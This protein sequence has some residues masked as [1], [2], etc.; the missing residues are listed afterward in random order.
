MR[1][2]WSRLRWI[3]SNHPYPQLDSRKGIKRAT[4]SSRSVFP[5]LLVFLHLNTQSFKSP[6]TMLSFNFVLF[7]LAL[8]PL[9]LGKLS[10]RV[11][12]WVCWDRAYLFLRPAILPLAHSL[13][14][15]LWFCLISCDKQEID[16]I[17]SPTPDQ[18]LGPGP[19][20]LKFKARPST[21]YI[22]LA[23]YSEDLTV[24]NA[25]NQRYS[26]LEAGRDDV[27][28]ANEVYIPCGIE[29]GKYILTVSRLVWGVKRREVGR[30]AGFSSKSLLHSDSLIYHVIRLRTT[31][32][33]RQVHH[34][35]SP[36]TSWVIGT[37]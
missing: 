12:R 11:S 19:F 30:E 1:S 29:S 33:T 2:N 9:A 15:S 14:F 7:S 17:C 3:D 24:K 10:P 21:D 22:E 20:D 32:L 35:A 26:T 34:Q 25:I 23:F 27:F 6:P 36:K 31:T 16:T 8:A 5:H 37:I 13:I 18:A 4:N 28:K